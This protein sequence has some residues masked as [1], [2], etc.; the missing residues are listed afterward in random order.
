[1]SLDMLVI[2]TALGNYT[3]K[4]H[5]LIHTMV[6]TLLILAEF[7]ILMFLDYTRESKLRTLF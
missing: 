6:A 7:V 1:M 4:L 3:Q 5:F 2:A